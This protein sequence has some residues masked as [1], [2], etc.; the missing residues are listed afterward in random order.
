MSTRPIVPGSGVRVRCRGGVSPALV[1]GPLRA[2][3]LVWV[4]LHGAEPTL[5]HTRDILSD[6]EPEQVQDPAQ[7]PSLWETEIY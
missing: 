1:I 6:N 7:D 2:T 4:R 5:V 3:E